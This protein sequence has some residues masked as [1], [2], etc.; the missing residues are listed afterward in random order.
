MIWYQA[1]PWSQQQQHFIPSGLNQLNG[2]RVS[3]SLGG[4]SINFYDLVTNL[5]RRE[6]PG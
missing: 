6:Q 1:S 2:S 5:T 3:D 4:F